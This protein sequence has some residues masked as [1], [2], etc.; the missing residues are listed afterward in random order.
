MIDQ[1]THERQLPA[2]IS[3]LGIASVAHPEEN[4]LSSPNPSVSCYYIYVLAVIDDQQTQQSSSGFF[5][6]AQNVLITGGT[7]IVSLCCSCV[8]DFITNPTDRIFSLLILVE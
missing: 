1:T 4:P 8:C 6:N 2:S 5:P 7:F 3:T